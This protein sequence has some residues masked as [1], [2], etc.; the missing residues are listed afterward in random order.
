LILFPFAQGEQH[1]S[2]FTTIQVQITNG[3]TLEQVLQE[4]DY[5][6][7]RDAMVRGYAG[8]KIKADYVVRQANGYDLGFRKRG[9]NY[10]L[11][12]D[13]WG[14]QI[15]EKAFVNEVSRR[16]AHKSLLASVQNQGFT[17]EQE[18]TLK[19]GSVRVVVGRW[20]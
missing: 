15:D 17:I 9:E 6:V 12:A 13:F 19:D 20:V 7:D 4:L 8:N 11:I 16:Y 10:E 14:A 2:H 3:E 1:M 5:Q 18:E